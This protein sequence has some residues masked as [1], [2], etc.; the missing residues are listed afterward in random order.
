MATCAAPITERDNDLPQGQV[1]NLTRVILAF[2]QVGDVCSLFISTT[3]AVAW[4]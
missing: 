3:I 4:V 1:E 2:Q